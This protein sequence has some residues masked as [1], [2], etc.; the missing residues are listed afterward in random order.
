MGLSFIFSYTQSTYLFT[1][2]I[3]NFVKMCIVIKMMN[4]RHFITYL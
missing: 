1:E 2:K 3:K 4:N